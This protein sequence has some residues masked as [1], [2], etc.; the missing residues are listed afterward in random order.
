[1][2]ELWDANIDLRTGM[3]ERFTLEFYFHSRIF[4]MSSTGWSGPLI[5]SEGK[6]QENIW[7]LVQD[8]AGPRN[9]R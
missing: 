2:N 8:T 6:P 7:Q 1:M 5:I 4:F 9:S 3:A